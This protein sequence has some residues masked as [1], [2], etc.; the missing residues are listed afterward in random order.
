GHWVYWAGPLVGGGLA[1]L[2]YELFFISHSHELLPAG[3]YS[4]E[5]GFEWCGSFHAM[6]SFIM[7]V[8]PRFVL[9]SASL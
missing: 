7:L 2:V 5:L 6:L 3:E 8:V 9:L 4:L 1:G